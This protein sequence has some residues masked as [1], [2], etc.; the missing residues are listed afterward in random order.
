[1]SKNVLARYATFGQSYFELDRR[2]FPETKPAGFFCF[3]KWRMQANNPLSGQ[4]AFT[5]PGPQMTLV[6]CRDDMIKELRDAIESRLHELLPLSDSGANL[7]SQAMHTGVLAPG[8]RFRSVLMLLTCDGLNGNASAV[9]DLACAVEMVHTASLFMDDLPCMDNARTRRGQRAAHV[10]YGEDV[11]MLAAVA[12]ISE[13]LRLVASVN[14]L[15]ADVRSELVVLLSGAL[16]P[17]GLAKGQ[18]LD[19]RNSDANR[20]EADIA[21]VNEQKTGVL[22]AAAL[23]MA[24]LACGANNVARAALREAAIHIG[25]AFQMRDDLEDKFDTD[26]KPMKDRNRDHGKTNMVSL[27]GRET[28]HIRMHQ[29]LTR[30]VAHLRVGLPN[31]VRTAEYFLR[32]FGLQLREVEHHGAS[33]QTSDF[34]IRIQQQC[35]T[36]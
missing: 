34:D 10:Q 2:T 5:K 4:A 31:H 6:A 18:Y 19:L 17:Q 20:S 32:A 9:L 14:G 35:V 12:L 1:M 3:Y 22:F 26:V 13:A 33:F 23:D 21:L 29:H 7:L 27:L 36:H 8:K 16:G 25:Q 24:A 28:V 30:A 15:P 11:A